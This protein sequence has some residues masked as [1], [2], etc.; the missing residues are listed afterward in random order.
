MTELT[1][2][3]WSIVLRVY[4][5]THKC[6]HNT[7]VYTYAFVSTWENF[8]VAVMLTNVVGCDVR[9]K[10]ILF[11]VVERVSKSTWFCSRGSVVVVVV[12]VIV[13]HSLCWISLHISMM[14]DHKNESHAVHERNAVKRFVH[15]LLIDV[16][17][18][19]T[20]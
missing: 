14:N 10:G 13:G 15:V 16:Q 19:L 6:T 18:I 20:K 8:T 2:S 11:A 12:G 9:Y 4:T 5:R 17:I 7:R 3:N 1:F